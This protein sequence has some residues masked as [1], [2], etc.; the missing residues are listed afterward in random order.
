MSQ[1]H[2]AELAAAISAATRKRGGD[3]ELR[4]L[5]HGVHRMPGFR[6]IRGQVAS[7]RKHTAAE[8]KRSREGAQCPYLVARMPGYSRFASMQTVPAELVIDRLAKGLVPID[9]A[10][11][12]TPGADA[13]QDDFD[14]A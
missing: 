6:G 1:D 8:W 11:R 9:F 5:L 2:Y 12:R 13:Q 4:Q 10:W 14:E 3:D 7:L